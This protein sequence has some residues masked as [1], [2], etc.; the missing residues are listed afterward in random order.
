M[1]GVY[2]KENYDEK[3]PL[4]YVKTEKDKKAMYALLKLFNGYMPVAEI[5]KQADESSEKLKA[6]TKAQAM[7]YIT[8][9]GK[10]EYEANLKNLDALNGELQKLSINLAKG[11]V[12]ADSIISE[13]AV[14]LKNV[15]SRLRKMRSSIKARLQTLNVS[16]QYS[17]SITSKNT[18]ELLAFFPNVN[19]KRLADIEQFH[20]DISKIF[21]K[22]LKEERDKLIKELSVCEK[23]IAEYEEE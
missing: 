15:L 1:E 6:Y 23:T 12:D 14:E 2:G 17:F 8:K 16:G 7:S 10:R 19:V 11:I 3:H 9:I 22:E 21:R 5:A 4:T 20:N 13:K 18:D